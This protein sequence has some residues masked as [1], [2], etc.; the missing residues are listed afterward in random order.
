MA[1]ISKLHSGSIE[2]PGVPGRIAGG[3]FA[4]G[5]NNV[6]SGKEGAVGE[7]SANSGLSPQDRSF[8]YH[9]YAERRRGEPP[10][11]EERAGAIDGSGLNKAP[12]LDAPVPKPAEEGQEVASPSGR[13]SSELATR[14]TDSYK[15][16][17][18]S[19]K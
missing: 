15:A 4:A 16:V 6:A 9:E 5:A 18:K 8:L 11:P 13:V 7:T 2:K 1:D 12:I 10:A 19:A 3:R 17:A 14:A